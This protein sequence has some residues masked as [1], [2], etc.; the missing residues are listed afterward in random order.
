MKS[1]ASLRLL[2]PALAFCLAFALIACQE[3]GSDSDGQQ[4]SSGDAEELVRQY[5]DRFNEQDL[6]AIKKLWTDSLVYN[7]ERIGPEEFEAL[8]K[9]YWGAFP[10]INTEITHV[11]SEGEQVAVRLMF[12]GTGE[13]EYLGHDVDGKSFQM[14]EIA[15]FH[16]SD[17]K[18]DEYWFQ[19]DE[20]GLWTQLGVLERPYPEE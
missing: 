16:V 2:L 1:P 15:I 3:V 12:E 18:F 6:N 13:G 5:R 4:A 20:L 8:H 7:G 19:F 11:V 10:D 14:S 9:S 17:G